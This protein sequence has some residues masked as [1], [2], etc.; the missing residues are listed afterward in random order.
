MQI[1]K[2][3]RHIKLTLV[4]HNSVEEVEH[5]KELSKLKYPLK[6]PNFS[7]VSNTFLNFMLITLLLFTIV[8]M[9]VDVFLNMKLLYFVFLKIYINKIIL[10]VLLPFS[11]FTQH[12]YLIFICVI[13]HRSTWFFLMLSVF[14]W[15]DIPQFLHPF[16]HVL[17][18]T[19]FW[20]FLRYA[21]CLS[22][23]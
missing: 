9:Q 10:N 4:I 1:N 18:D 15:L 13:S 14:H 20:T 11:F 2:K 3:Y 17:H 21:F 19:I 5:Y 8:L 22:A 12:C 23:K 6:S 16:Q 7:L